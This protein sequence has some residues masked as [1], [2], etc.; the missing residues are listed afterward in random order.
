MVEVKTQLEVDSEANHDESV[1]KGGNA[2]V[3]SITGVE[4]ENVAVIG[5]L[6][7]KNKQPLNKLVLQ[8][9]QALGLIRL[10]DKGIQDLAVRENKI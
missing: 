8:N 1:L 7:D 3:S 5:G 10:K 2:E 6:A 4:L 9:L